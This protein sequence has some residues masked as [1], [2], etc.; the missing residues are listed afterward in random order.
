MV[1]IAERDYDP[2]WPEIYTIIEHSIKGKLWVTILKI[3]LVRS[4][5]VPDLIS[6]SVIDIGYIKN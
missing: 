1:V 4:T 3:Y 6:K 2:A 5:A